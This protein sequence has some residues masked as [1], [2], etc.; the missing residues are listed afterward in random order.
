M[1]SKKQLTKLKDQLTI[2]FVI[3][4]L[5]L[6]CFKINAWALVTSDI[7]IETPTITTGN[8]V[9]GGGMTATLYG[10]INPYNYTLTDIRFEYG[11]TSGQYNK[12][13]LTTPD[14]ASGTSLIN[15]VAQVDSLSPLNF[16]YRLICMIGNIRYYGEEKTLFINP[17]PQLTTGDASQNNNKVKLFG[18]INPANRVFLDLKF[19]YGPDTNYGN[20][21]ETSPKIAKGSQNVEVTGIIT[22]LPAGYYHYRLTGT[23][24]NSAIYNGQDKTFE[25]LSPP[26]NALIFNGGYVDISNGDYSSITNKI[27]I[28]LWANGNSALPNTTTVFRAIGANTSTRI[29]NIHLPWSNGNVYFDAGYESNSFDRIN[30]N[31]QEHEYKNQWNHWAFVKDA[32]GIGTMIIYLNGKLWHSGTGM[33]RLI[34]G[35]GIKNC[36]I[37]NSQYIYL[38][39]IDEFRIWNT[40]RTQEDIQNNM[41]KT[42]LGTETGLVA[43]YNFDH[44]SG[45]LLADL[46]NNNHGTLTNMPSNSWVASN[47]IIPKPIFLTGSASIGAGGTT[48]KLNGRVNPLNQNITNIGFEYGLTSDYGSFVN[49]SPQA[50]TSYINV[51]AAIS[52]LTP[53]KLYNY[54]LVGK[55]GQTTITGQ[56][57]KIFSSTNNPVVTTGE[58]ISINSTGVKVSGILNPNGNDITKILFEYYTVNNSK[59][60]TQTVTIPANSGVQNLTRIASGTQDIYVIAT[61]SNLNQ[62]DLY[63]Y[64]LKAIASNGLSTTGFEQTFNMSSSAGLWIG[65]IE[66]NQVNEVGFKSTDSQTPKDVSSPFEMKIILHVDTAGTVNLLRQVT[67][68]QKLDQASNKVKRVLITDD[69]LLPDYEGVVRRDGKLVG[70]RMSTVF[71]DYDPVLNE[72]PLN[73]AIGEGKTVSGMLYLSKDN[74]INPFKHLYH[75]DHKTGIDITREIKMTFDPQDINNPQSGVYNLK[76]IYEETLKGVHKIPIKMKGTFVLNRVSVIANLN[77]Q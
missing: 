4:L 72:L 18:I 29:L 40:A 37:G 28:E 10:S 45:T 47:A 62:T 63:Y 30:K 77:A 24:I 35:A 49:A 71:F 41:H 53:N 44:S 46:A 56:N 59:L 65:Q 34:D 14:T 33:T 32:T 57:N 52:S 5:F 61:L 73:G 3:M 68:M 64:R 26:G 1:K 2:L 13:I 9:Q 67:L 66:L 27:T 75:P 25:V 42:L 8:A 6:L 17:L 23:T 21:I 50:T 60:L 7:P 20:T 39:I 11:T 15:V 48:S 54:R 70:I 38:G 58:V 43:Y 16:Y 74:P 22:V 31:A 12:N 19:E 69:N 76:G 51:K 36:Q 55:I